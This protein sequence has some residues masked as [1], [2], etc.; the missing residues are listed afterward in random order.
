MTYIKTPTQ[1]QTTKQNKT[2]HIKTD[3]MCGH[4]GIH[5]FVSEK[6]NIPKNQKNRQNSVQ[7]HCGVSD[8]GAIFVF[9][10]FALVFSFTY[11][12]FICFVVVEV[13]FLFG[14]Y[15]YI[16]FISANNLIVISKMS[17]L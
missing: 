10:F 2:K 12:Y 5:I 6:K 3:I 1:K 16:Y 9:V 17:Y 4:N 15:I 7:K 8:H 13:L 11:F 14:I